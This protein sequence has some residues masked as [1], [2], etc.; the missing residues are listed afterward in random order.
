MSEDYGIKYEFTAPARV[1]LR[2]VF[3]A[4]PSD[5]VATIAD[6]LHGEAKKEHG[7]FGIV[8]TETREG[9]TIATVDA[10]PLGLFCLDY[11]DTPAENVE[12]VGDARELLKRTPATSSDD[13]ITN[14]VIREFAG[15]KDKVISY[16][17]AEAKDKDNTEEKRREAIR[18]LAEY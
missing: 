10:K 16:L 17:L 8:G 7:L 2:T 13:P 3:N 4:S 5:D 6:I 15:S 11:R 9:T 14:T 1:L 18:I 12:L